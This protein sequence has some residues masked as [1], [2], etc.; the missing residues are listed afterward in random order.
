MNE[1]N[2]PIH[3]RREPKYTSALTSD[4]LKDIFD[5]CSD[6]QY[7]KIKSGLLGDEIFVCWLDGIVNTSDI[8][9]DLLRPLTDIIRSGVSPDPEKLMAGAVYAATANKRDSLD[10]VVNDITQGNAAV[11]F[12]D[13]QEAVCFELRSDKVRSVS[14][15]TI[16]KSVK[17]A[18]DSFVE[19]LRTNTALVRRRI[20]D[21]ALKVINNTVGRKSATRCAVMFVDGVADPATVS[22]LTRRLD[23]IDIDG[24]LATGSIEEYITDN[25]R[26]PLP[27]LLHSERPDRFARQL[28]NGRVGLIVDGLPMGFLLPVTLAEFMRVPQDD[29]QHYTIATVLGFVRWLALIL[30]LTLPAFYVAVAM[31]HQEMIP[32]KLLLSVIQSK[33]DVPFSTALEVFGMLIAFEL[34]QEASLRLP[35]A[36]G[37]TVSIIGALIVGQSAVEAKVISPI[38]V[39]IVAVAGISGFAQPSQDLSAAVRI[40]RLVLV[41]GAMAAGLYGVTALLC[42]MV[43]HLCT[44]N[45]FGVNYSAPLSQGRASRAFIRRPKPQ[46][47]LR[48]AELN[49]P[50]KRKQA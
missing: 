36:V 43:W 24:L 29:S 35:D 7:R 42:L 28:L 10:D 11:V 15:P 8:A 12:D 45:S 20:C 3:P 31:Y 16:E 27:Q 21:P 5:R 39:I 4:T 26:S 25:P 40:G 48:E 47:K 22:E 23:K 14:E 33:Q 44:V 1:K 34:L 19:V 2:I 41:L 6:F 9:S 37:S 17:G 32:T 49:T 46:D 50:D 38:A 13:A 30:A 18:K